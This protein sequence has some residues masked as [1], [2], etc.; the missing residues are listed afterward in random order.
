MLRDRLLARLTEMGPAP[1]HQTLAAEVLGIRGASPELARRLV[2][3]AL[4]LEDRRDVWRRTGARICA[5]APV[6][7]GVYILRDPDGVVIYVGKAN[8]LRRRLRAHFADRRWRAL[9]PAMSRIV[10]AEWIEVG[11][12]LEALLR[13]AMLIDELA[14]VVNVQVERPPYAPES[15]PRTLVRDVVVLLPSVE[16]D[17]VEL[18]CARPV[19]GSC[20]IQ[21]TRRSGADLAVHGRR[22]LRFFR[23][24]SE[25]RSRTPDLE[26][27]SIVYAWLA[28]RGAAATRLDP[29]DARSP[30]ELAMRLAALLRDERLFHERL[31]QC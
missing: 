7:P 8:N 24:A 18:I 2:A 10:D 17:S 22:L 12:E 28:R 11:S 14:P 25:V 31:H 16:A 23:S 26:L 5:E 30:K 13:E 15:V 27:A 4:V 3:Q 6:T 21:R 9:K 19:D 20:L 29:S 1:D